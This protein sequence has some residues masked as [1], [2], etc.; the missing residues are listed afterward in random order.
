V[1]GTQIGGVIGDVFGTGST[2]E[3]SLYAYEG[4]VMTVDPTGTQNLNANVA[5]L[6]DVRNVAKQTAILN[7]TGNNFDMTVMSAP[8]EVYPH[9]KTVDGSANVPGQMPG[10]P[11]PV[12]MILSTSENTKSGLYISDIVN[13]SLTVPQNNVDITYT[14]DDFNPKNN[15]N[16]GPDAV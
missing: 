4:Q 3:A 1:T 14:Y 7:A 12:A 5:T 13:A 6:N 9:V 8:N 16:S 2:A 11:L 10:T 15:V